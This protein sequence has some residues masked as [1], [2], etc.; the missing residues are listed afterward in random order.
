MACV[1]RSC[2]ILSRMLSEIHTMEKKIVIHSKT[3]SF[4]VVVKIFIQCQRSNVHVSR[5]HFYKKKVAQRRFNRNGY[6]SECKKGKS[7]RE[8]EGESISNQP[9]PFSDGPR[10]SRFSCLVSIHDLYVGTKLHAYRVILY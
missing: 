1:P 7:V 2:Q 10:R 9:I 3:I 4:S 6:N 5:R 8:Y